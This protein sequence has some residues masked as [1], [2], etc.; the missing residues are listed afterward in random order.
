MIQSKRRML[1]AQKR[2]ARGDD[3]LRRKVTFSTE[4]IYFWDWIINA[5]YYEYSWISFSPRQAGLIGD[6]PGNR[7]LTKPLTVNLIWA[8]KQWR[9]TEPTWLLSSAGPTIRKAVANFRRML[10]DY[11][12]VLN[13]PEEDLRVIQDLYDDIKRYLREM[14]EELPT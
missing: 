2:L 13:E 4:D 9:I 11:L 3:V 14:I 12:D 6:L 10:S 1:V 5:P 8:K 7:Q